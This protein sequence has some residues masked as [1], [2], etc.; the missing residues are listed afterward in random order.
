MRRL[1]VIAVPVAIAALLAG[2]SSSSPKAAPKP[3]GLGKGVVH[4]AHVGASL[5]LTTKTGRQFSVTLST[6]TDPAQ[7]AGSA[8]PSTMTRFVAVNLTIDNTS[9]QSINPAAV[10]DTIA[11]GSG[12]QVYA[13]SNVKLADC[14]VFARGHVNIGAGSS[15]TGCVAFEIPTAV[16]ITEVQFLPTAGTAGNYG[17]WLNP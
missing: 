1:M 14:T 16:T 13:D 2:C 3:P 9:G 17:E 5:D 15:A 11:V 7:G 12:G 10:R 8:H 4:Q 6:I